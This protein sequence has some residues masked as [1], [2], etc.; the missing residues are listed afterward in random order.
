MLTFQLLPGRCSMRVCFDQSL[1]STF[2]FDYIFVVF[3]NIGALK[4]SKGRKRKCVMEGGPE[5]FGNLLSGQSEW[6]PIVHLTLPRRCTRCGLEA[7]VR[8]ILL[9]APLPMAPG[10][11]SCGIWEFRQLCSSVKSLTPMGIKRHLY[12]DGGLFTPGLQPLWISLNLTFPVSISC[13]AM[14]IDTKSS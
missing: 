14:G 5:K 1:S 8:W 7:E 12:G 6:V 9:P 4:Q 11:Q 13:P 2:Y 3:Y 10:K